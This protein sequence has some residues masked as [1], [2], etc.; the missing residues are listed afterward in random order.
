MSFNSV[1]EKYLLKDIKKLNRITTYRFM[2]IL[3]VFLLKNLQLYNII[4]PLNT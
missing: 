1:D 4:I 3:E 2:G